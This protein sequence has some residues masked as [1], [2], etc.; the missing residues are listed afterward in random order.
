MMF[1]AIYPGTFDPITFGHLDVIKSSLKTFDKII[2]GVADGIHKKTLFSVEER[3]EMVNH[4]LKAHGFEDRAKAMAFSGLL[5]DFAEDNNV[6]VLVRGL[7]AVSDFEYEIQLSHANSSI[8]DNIQTILIPASSSNQFIASS[9]VKE[10]ARLG[11]DL[12]KFVSENVAN[13]LSRKF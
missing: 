7:R 13:E 10:V 1:N 11:G 5:V 4:E 8:N 9:I 2:I 3:V 12:S 6:N